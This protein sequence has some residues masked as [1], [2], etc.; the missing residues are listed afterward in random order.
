MTSEL[1][2]NDPRIDLLQ[3]VPRWPPDDLPDPYIG[4][5]SYGRLNMTLIYCFI[6]H[7]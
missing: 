4:P 7:C 2:Q 5:Q 3:L 6:D 1:T